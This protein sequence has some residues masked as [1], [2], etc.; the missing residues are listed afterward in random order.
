MIL[1]YNQL[2]DTRQ[3]LRSLRN[4]QY[5][6]RSIYVLD[7]G[8]RDGSLAVLPSEFPECTFIDNQANLGFAGGC[9][10]GIERVLKDG[11]DAVMLLN[12]DLEVDPAFLSE[13]VEV[14]RSHDK[15]AVVGAVNYELDHR[16]VL[17]SAGH[18]INLW[19]GTQTKL[20]PSTFAKI[21][22]TS[23]LEEPLRVQCVPGSA[24]L[25]RREVLE[26]V[27]LLD[28][29]F[30]IY[31]EE[32][33]FCLRVAEAGWECWIVPS[34]KIWHRVFSSLGQR[35]PAIHYICTRNL[36]LLVRKHG[37]PLQRA[38]FLL[39]N[40]LYLLAKSAYF[41]LRGRP[42]A[43]KAI[44]W[45]W[46]DYWRGNWEIGRLQEVRDWGA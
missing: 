22:G 44:A 43:A 30:F 42:C 17:F 25:I 36:L 45:G 13:L 37:T 31:Y 40:T 2:E 33:D 15:V 38:S 29:R 8:S 24:F 14:L 7:N 19:T 21:L 4:L 35:S 27:G 10:R 46:I 5:A 28:E 34:S 6:D 9:N 1:N 23:R 16:E 12:N 41:A 11:A 32:S 20:D 26:E 39:Y 3:C 18:R